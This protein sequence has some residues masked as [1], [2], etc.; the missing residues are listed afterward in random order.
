MS[1]LPADPVAED[2]LIGIPRQQTNPTRWQG[3]QWDEF[4]QVLHQQDVKV[5]QKRFDIGTYVTDA[6]GLAFGLPH[7][8]VMAQSAEQIATLMQ[9]AQQFKVPVS[10][11]GGGLTT[12]GVSVAFGGILLYMTGMSRVIQ[13]DKSALT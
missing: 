9:T 5:R 4:V 2:A 3:E 11:R 8:V 10:V 6:G 12:E 1:S 7:G 13:I